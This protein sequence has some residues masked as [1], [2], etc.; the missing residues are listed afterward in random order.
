MSSDASAVLARRVPPGAAHGTPAVSVRSVAKTFPTGLTALTDVSF[1]V[2]Q[3]GFTSVL[4]ASG[5]GK[6]TLLRM[7]AGLIP[8]SAGE[9]RLHGER[10]DAPPPSLIY[11]FQ[12]YTKS[13]LPWRT[14]LGNV[15]FGAQSPRAR[16]ASDRP[17]SESDCME[18][19]ELVGLKGH[20]HSYPAQLSGGMQQRVA[21][22]RALVARPR[23]LLMD[24]PFSALDALTRESLQ[25]LLLKLWHDV[26]LTVVFVTHD[27]GEAIYLSDHIVALGGTPASVAARIEVKVDR[28]R[29]QVSTRESPAFLELR[30]SLYRMVVGR[31]E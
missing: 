6:S 20:E 5:C 27:I 12:Q 28:P 25:D 1:E 31:E 16:G 15:M 29:H 24:E 18:Y 9:I 13:L 26:S 19:I 3:D 23:I 22:A 14:V 30:R 4:G 2:A 10:V 7:I 17:L 8:V 11:V 21:I